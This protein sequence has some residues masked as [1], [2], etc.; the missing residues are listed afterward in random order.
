MHLCKKNS[1]FIILHLI[2]L[3]MLGGQILFLLTGLRNSAIYYCCMLFE[4]FIY[5]QTYC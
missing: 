4:Y 3:N 5:G 2:V 1:N